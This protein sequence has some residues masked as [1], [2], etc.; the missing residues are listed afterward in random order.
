MV[1]K[2]KTNET[3]CLFIVCCNNHKLRSKSYFSV[4]DQLVICSITSFSNRV[5]GCNYPGTRARF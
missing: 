1:Q 4:A 3:S 2:N 5:P